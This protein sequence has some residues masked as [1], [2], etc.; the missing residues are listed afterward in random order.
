MG[1]ITSLFVHKVIAEADES[2]DRRAFLEK[3]GIDP[4]APVDPK[5]MVSDTD[6]YDFFAA[7]AHADPHGLELPLRVGASMRCEDYGAFGN[8]LLT[9][10]EVTLDGAWLDEARRLAV[11][12]LERFGEKDRVA[13][14]RQACTSIV[15]NNILPFG[16]LLQ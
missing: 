16:R 9:L 2:L 1:Q 10:H 6:Y 13:L 14:Q 4:D 5:V 3:T 11:E 8:A 15:R 12:I 7:L